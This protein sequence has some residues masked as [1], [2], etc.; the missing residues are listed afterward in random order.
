MSKKWKIALAIL[1]MLI[2]GVAWVKFYSFPEFTWRQRMI[3]EVNVNGM[4]VSGSSVIENRVRFS[5]HWVPS[6]GHRHPSL[7]GEAVVVDM[8]E[9]GYLFALLRSEGRIGHAM[10]LALR[11]YPELFHD[12]EGRLLSTSD[13]FDSPYHTLRD[14][15]ET[16]EIPRDNYPMLVTFTDINDPKTVQL[17]D[18]DDLAATF[19]ERVSLKRI[20]LEITSD[21]LT[22]RIVGVLGWLPQ[23]SK[24][25]LDGSPIHNSTDLANRLH[26]GNFQ[27]G[28]NQ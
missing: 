24:G 8:G 1:A 28:V 23:R 6:N 15:R 2:G 13:P 26:S 4:I 18:P 3:V 17:V 25:Y 27:T 21:P 7:V 10:S 12:S 14:L 16:R 19:G 11:L 20:T 22:D 5:P 9:R